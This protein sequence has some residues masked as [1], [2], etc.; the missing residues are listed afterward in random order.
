MVGLIC[1]L[2]ASASKNSYV[3][4]QTYGIEYLKVQANNLSGPEKKA[5]AD[6]V[7]RGVLQFNSLVRAGQT[8]HA[9]YQWGHAS[10]WHCCLQLLVIAAQQS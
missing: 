8:L 1:L 9:W 7:S 4:K 5:G 6:W 2:V 3:K 10:A